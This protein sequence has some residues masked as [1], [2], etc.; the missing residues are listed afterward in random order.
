MEWVS[1][2]GSGMDRVGVCRR[3]WIPSLCSLLFSVGVMWAA[4]YK[5]DVEEHVGKML[6]REKEDGGLLGK[7]VDELKKKGVEFDL[8]KEVDALRRAKSL[9]IEGEVVSKWNAKDFV[10][11]FF[12]FVSCLVLGLIRVILCG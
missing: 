10:T 7:C 11:L 9:K 2:P 4:R 5:S 8:M 1:G 12:F 6:K 3:S